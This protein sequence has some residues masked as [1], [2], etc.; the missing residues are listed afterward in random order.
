[1]S[2]LP[3]KVLLSIK[4]SDSTPSFSTSKPVVTNFYH[5]NA[6]RSVWSSPINTNFPFLISLKNMFLL[7]LSLP[8]TTVSLK[9]RKSMTKTPYGLP[10]LLNLISPLLVISLHSK[11]ANYTSYFAIALNL[12]RNILQK[13]HLQTSLTLFNLS[14]ACV[15][16]GSLGKSA[17]SIIEYLLSCEFFNSELC[18]SLLLRI[19][20]KQATD[21]VSSIIDYEI[22]NDQPV[23]MKIYHNHI[24]YIS[25]VVFKLNAHIIELSLYEDLITL[26]TDVPTLLKNLSAILLLK[27]RLTR[28]YPN[29]PN[30]FAPGP[31]FP[32]NN[33]SPNK[34]ISE[35]PYPVSI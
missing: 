11:S 15:L 4:R 30:T 29:S 27:S 20:Q 23:K 9:A 17:S 25:S 19:V 21:I 35:F 7:W 16:T 3:L 31:Y 28:L 12:S 26:N 18:K 8:I 14:L 2:L 33:A 24:D 1:M 32:Q 5:I 10:P 6:K 22:S 34:K 13:I